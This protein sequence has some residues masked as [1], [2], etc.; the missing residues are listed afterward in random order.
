LRIIFSFFLI[1]LFSSS[2]NAQKIA[3]IKIS[4][5]ISNSIAYVDF[6]KKLNIT[7]LSYANSLK[8]DEK[9]LKHKE[10]KIQDSKL[11]LDETSLNNLIENYNKDFQSYQNKVNNFNLN[12]DNTI[13]S[14]QKII[15]NEIIPI[16]QILSDSMNIDIILNED[17]YF[18]SS[19][20]SDISD[21]VLD[22]LNKK[23][24]KLKIFKIKQ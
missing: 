16:T 9:E 1:L 12:I 22:E 23:T 14:N 8:E 2:I 6:I 11:I 17:Q 18:L 21:I 13:N 19:H 4:Y 10:G 24:I 20:D 3:T 5:L 7:K 15:I